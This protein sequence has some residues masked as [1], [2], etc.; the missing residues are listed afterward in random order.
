M[1]ELRGRLLPHA[2]R[3]AAE[4]VI[5]DWSVV[6][7][8]LGHWRRQGA[9]IGF[10]NGCFDILH[11][12]HIKVLAQTHALCDRL[13]VGLNSDASV[14]RLKGNGRPMQNVYARAEVLAALEA[15]DLVVIFDEDTPFELIRRVRP[16]LLAKGGDYRRKQVVGHELVEAYGG[17]VVLIDLVPSFS[18]TEIVH[19]ARALQS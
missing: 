15:V 19:K 12:G 17:E 7:E 13:I 18:T 8:R 3:A 2:S 6:D 4:K 1:T 14:R 5:F 9:R 11:P 10:T 16:Q